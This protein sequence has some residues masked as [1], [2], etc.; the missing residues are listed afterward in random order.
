MTTFTRLQADP[1]AARHARCL[2]LAAAAVGSAQIRNVATVGGNVANASPC[3]DSIPA[4]LALGAEVEVWDGA[5]QT[6]RRPLKPCWPAPGRPR[7][8]L[9]RSSPAFPSPL[10]ATAFARRSP[11]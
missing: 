2:A 3:G 10:S 1:L 8:A 4:L 11:R 5:G 7:W 6:L 9:A